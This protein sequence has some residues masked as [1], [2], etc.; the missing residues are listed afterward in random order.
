MS[1]MRCND[2]EPLLP[3]LLHGA[4]EP[5]VEG[6]VREH[7]DAC[8]SCR[9]ELEF[10]VRLRRSRL[11][12]PPELVTGIQRALREEGRRTISF[13]IPRWAISAAAVLVLS[14]GTVVIW[15]TRGPAEI[16]PFQEYAAE[17]EPLTLFADDAMVAGAPSFAGL[18]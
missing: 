18:A 17:P 5:E 10:L 12:P 1:E 4:L 16:D 7:L 11:E 3:D 9:E 15:Q 2:V 13:G 8:G 14:L 6:E